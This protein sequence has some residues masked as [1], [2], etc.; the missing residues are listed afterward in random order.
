M[1]KDPAGRGAPVFVDPSGRRA[2]W[3]RVLARIAVAVGAVLAGLMVVSVF[4]GVPMPGLTAPV[5][6]HSD[7]RAHPADRQPP[8][9][10]SAISQPGRV[11]PSEPSGAATTAS[12]PK[13]P[14][15][16]QVRSTPSATSTAPVIPVGSAS[17]STAPVP[18]STPTPN[19]HSSRSTSHSPNPRSSRSARTHSALPRRSHAAASP[20]RGRSSSLAVLR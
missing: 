17:S 2:R 7:E 13:P 3:V 4:G 15:A 9:A 16:T 6:L 1:P 5:V 19:P 12:A 18:A 11:N 8:V 20:G 10:D 14:P